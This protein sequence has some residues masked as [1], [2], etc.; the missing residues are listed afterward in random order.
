MGDADPGADGDV[1]PDADGDHQDARVLSA[2]CGAGVVVEAFF[3]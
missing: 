2:G 3:Q 1:D